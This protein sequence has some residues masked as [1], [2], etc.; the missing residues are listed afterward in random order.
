[1]VWYFTSA[2]AHRQA[3]LEAISKQNL[4]HGVLSVTANDPELVT[5]FQATPE[6]PISQGSVYLRSQSEVILGN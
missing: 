3:T 6:A 4:V 1:M 2:V 5:G